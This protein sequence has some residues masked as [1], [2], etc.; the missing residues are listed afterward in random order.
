VL[1][2]GDRT[3]QQFA[4]ALPSVAVT[5]IRSGSHSFADAGD[6]VCEAIVASCRAVTGVNPVTSTLG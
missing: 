6:A 1:A 2:E 5:T 4:T 3:A